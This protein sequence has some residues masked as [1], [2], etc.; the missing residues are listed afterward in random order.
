MKRNMIS[1]SNLAIL[2]LLITGAALVLG[3]AGA[4]HAADLCVNPGGTDGCHSS[5]QSAV[6]SAGSGDT[7]NVE[8]GTYSESVT[9][10]K[11]LAFQANGVPIIQGCFS[12]STDS[13]IV[14]GLTFDGGDICPGAG[15]QGGIYFVADTSGHTISGNTLN[16]PGSDQLFRGLLFGHNIS[17]VSISG[18]NINNW[19]SGI[20]INPSSD[21]V[22]DGNT[23]QD[24]FVGIGSDG[25]SN[26]TIL[27]NDFIDNEVEGWG[28]SNI[29]LN[30]E[31]HNNKFNGNNGT[32]V[33]HY[34]GEVINAIN[35][36]WGDASG[37]A[38]ASNPGGAG[39]VVSDNVAYDPWLT[40]P[41]GPST[42]S[43]ASIVGAEP[44][45]FSEMANYLLV[46]LVPIAVVL[47]SRRKG[48]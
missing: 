21:I 15:E 12:M 39:D 13:V 41:A 43:A 46:L 11:S 18:N 20:Y 4:A 30:V 17:N 34:G 7:I 2:I 48:V 42:W 35:N 23:F 36:W 29:G 27:N 22:M 14:N 47:L 9:I 38:H 8:T 40:A 6:D 33:A 37:P 3:L 1:S 24:N 32:A 10:A 45:R 19:K 5:I 44:H 26:V 16:G 25:L 31:A 28:A